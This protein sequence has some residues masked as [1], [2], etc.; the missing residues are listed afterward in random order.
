MAEALYLNLD[1][2][3]QIFE[4]LK[5][6]VSAAVQEIESAAAIAMAGCYLVLFVRS[7][8]AGGSLPAP[9]RLRRRIASAVSE[10][11]PE[12]LYVIDCAEDESGALPD[13]A[14]LERVVAD[15]LDALGGELPGAVLVARYEIDRC[16]AFEARLG[17]IDIMPISDPRMRDRYAQH[18]LSAIELG[19]AGQ[20]GIA[21]N[22]A[23]TALAQALLGDLDQA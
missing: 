13:M 20:A 15:S 22:G 19:F 18:L 16:H 23:A 10:R 6:S 4:R 11:A 8:A 1:V 2:D 12:A 14:H 3:P 9:E 5:P 17:H 21:P 7:R